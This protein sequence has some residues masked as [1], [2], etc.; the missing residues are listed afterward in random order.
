MDTPDRVTPSAPPAAARY[1]KELDGLRAVAFLMVFF[2]HLGPPPVQP[3]PWLDGV[4]LF[5]RWGWA[6]VDLFF[7][8]SA[9]LIT[10]LLLTER[11]KHG[12][13]SFKLFFLRRALRIWPLFY[14]NLLLGLFVLP[15]LGWLGPS[16]G[17]P[18]WRAV[19]EVYGPAFA[20][21][22]GNF[23]MLDSSLE[24]TLPLV[25]RPMW[26]VCMEEQ[27]YLGWCTILL[28]VSR[29]RTIQGALWGFWLGSVMLRWTLQGQSTDFWPYYHHT[30]AHLDPIVVGALLGTWQAR[31]GLPAWGHPGGALACWAVLALA[32]PPLHQNHPSAVAIFPVIALASGWTL[33]TALQHPGWRRALS[34]PF[35]VRYGRLTYGLYMFHMLG[36]GLASMASWHFQPAASPLEFWLC[37]LV[38]GLGSTVAL[39]HLSWRFLEE[40]CF[41]WRRRLSRV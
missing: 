27:F 41:R 36:I 23:R 32:F 40:P 5:L 28:W 38:V 3:H 8:L 31:G 20:T 29:T 9:Y 2:F 15:W 39:A 19:L 14:V 4:G 13:I 24:P 17:T 11:A 37:Q 33:L 30:L 21:F 7:V 26:S 34:H 16:W 10:Y 35:L 1:W 25:L 18:Q 12:G 22:L 6:G